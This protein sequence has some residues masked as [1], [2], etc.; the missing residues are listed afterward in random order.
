VLTD[1][2]ESI[3]S[4]YLV[5]CYSRLYGTITLEEEA[6]DF[7]GPE[8]QE[9]LAFIVGNILDDYENA[10]A[11]YVVNQVEGHVDFDNDSSLRYKFLEYLY[12]D[13]GRFEF[14]NEREKCIDK[15]IELEA[16]KESS[17]RP[18]KKR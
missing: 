12:N 13:P 17:C 11:R 1:A 15:L 3:R 4:D 14:F 9:R 7:S 6:K 16:I 5:G 18:I 8:S 2:V 10:A